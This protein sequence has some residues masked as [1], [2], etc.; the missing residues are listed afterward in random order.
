LGNAHPETSHPSL[1]GTRC[2]EGTTTG[3]LKTFLSLSFLRNYIL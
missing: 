3:L 2:V 1:G